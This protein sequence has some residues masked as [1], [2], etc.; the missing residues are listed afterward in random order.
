MIFARDMISR[1]VRVNLT[2]LRSALEYRMR[3]I[4]TKHST[5]VMAVKLSQ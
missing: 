4:V 5:G 1:P 2:S 3:T